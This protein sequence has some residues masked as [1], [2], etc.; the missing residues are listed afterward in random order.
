M[1]A[2]KSIDNYFYTRTKREA[3]YVY[4]LIAILIGFVIFYFIYPKTQMYAKKQHDLYNELLTKKSSL[5]TT[6]RVLL[7]RVTLLNKK[8]K[9]LTSQLE[10]LKK[11]KTFYTEL[12]SL[13]NF[14]N[15]DQYKWA[16]LVKE[17][18]DAAKNEGMKVVKISNNLYDDQNATKKTDFLVKRMDMD[19]YLRGDYKNFIF[20][21]YNFENRKD[22]IKVSEINVTSP[23][24]YYL[25]I[26]IY[27]FVK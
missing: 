3:V 14:A 21:V 8:I 4:L 16:Q 9:E 26:S 20:Y 15:F 5:E 13:L 24:K 18:V 19:I 23:T 25:K 22:L 12:T 10:V 7:A 2:L 11:Q 1:K 27:G 17:S 6:Q